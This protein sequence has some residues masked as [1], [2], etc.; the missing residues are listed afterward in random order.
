MIF[1]KTLEQSSILL[2]FI[3]IGYFLRK[4]EIINESGKKV[5]AGLL[6]NLFSPC[7]AIA[8]LSETL[9]IDK[10]NQYLFY[11]LTGSA[12]AIVI[13]FV[14][15]PFAKF[16]GKDKLEKNILKYALAFANIGYFGYPVVGAVFGEAFPGITGNM[17]LFCIPQ[18]IIINT[19]G[20]QILTEKITDT[21]NGL[22]SEMQSNKKKG[23]WKKH[24]RFMRSVPFIGTMLGVIIGLLP[25]TLPTYITNLLYKAADCQSATAMLLTGAV[26]ANVPF[27]KLFTSWKPYLIG[28]I[29]LLVIPL[30]L[31]V[32][33]YLLG[34]RGELFIISMACISIPV[35]MN[36]VV[37]PESAGLDST[38]G[39]KTCFIS[40]VLV[41]ATLPW[42]FK[43]LQIL[44]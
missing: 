28:F 42:V 3:F 19:Y 24:F 7:Y 10:V 9:T 12:L 34:I 44:A 27:L 17:I 16:L 2:I 6:V 33:M 11:L 40:Y 43:L 18:S 35:G 13:V 38:V 23:D 15:I 14:A 25:F 31:G 39:A 32:P 37:Y 30:V 41:V 1:T 8:N 22:V 26:L 29:R 4:K 36:V 20:Y 21:P 5:L